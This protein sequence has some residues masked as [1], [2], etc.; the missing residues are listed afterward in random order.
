MLTI[1]LFSIC[2][3]EYI[4]F[5]FCA[6]A[7]VIRTPVNRMI[8]NNFLITHAIRTLVTTTP[9]VDLGASRDKASPSCWRHQGGVLVLP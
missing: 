4:F 7:G 1:Y 8:N 5:S 3:Y 6:F 2:L 9:G